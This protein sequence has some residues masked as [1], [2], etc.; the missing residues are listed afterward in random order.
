MDLD[1]LPMED[2]PAAAIERSPAPPPPPA[3]TG[4]EAQLER[5]R[6]LED[7]MLHEALEVVGDTVN[8]ADVGPDDVDVPPEWIDKYGFEQAT[9]RFRRMKAAWMSSKHAPVALGIAASFATKIVKAR[10]VE[11]QAPRAIGIVVMVNEPAEKLEIIDVES[12]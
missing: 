10:A 4:R 2:V 12:D 1:D 11:K 5:I 7:Q 3:L 6:E 9:K 8:F